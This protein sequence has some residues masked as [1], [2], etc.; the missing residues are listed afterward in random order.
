MTRLSSNPYAPERL[1]LPP[2]MT[3]QEAQNTF[4]SSS[5]ADDSIDLKELVGTLLGGWPIIVGVTIAALLLSFTYLFTTAPIYTTDALV[6]VEANQNSARIAFAQVADAVGSELPVTAEVEILRSRLVLGKIVDQLGLDVI[7]APRRFPLLGDAYARRHRGTEFGRAPWWLAPFSRSG[8]AWGGE[9]IAVS[10]LIAPPSMLGQPLVVRLDALDGTFSLLDQDRHVMASGKAGELLSVPISDDEQ[11]QLFVRELTGNPGTEFIV[12]R[13]R[14][15]AAIR[16][17]QKN[18]TVTASRT[19]LG[20]VN[21]SYSDTSPQGARRVLDAILNAYQAQNVERRSA[22]AEQTLDFLNQQL[23]ELRKQVETAEARLNQFK[24]QQGTADLGQETALVL[25]RS[26]ELEQSRS[27]LLQQRNEALQRYTSIH[28]VVQA[29][30]SQLALLDGQLRQVNARVRQLPDVEQKALQLSRDLQVNTALYVSLLNRTQ[31]LEVVKSGTIGSIRVIDT[32]IVPASPSKPRRA[33]VL[34]LS[35]V[36]G[37]LIGVV[38]VFLINALSSGVEDPSEVEKKLGLATYG[39]IPYSV[40]QSKLAQ[41][42]D[43]GKALKDGVLAV[44]EPHGTAMEAI[45]SVRTALHFAAMDAPNNVIMLTGPEPSLGKSFVSINLGGALAQAGSRVIVIDADLRRG[46]IHKMVDTDR[47]P[48]LSEL[49]SGTATFEACHRDTGISGLHLIPTGTLPPNPS[50]LLINE[51]FVE[52]LNGLSARYDHVIIDTPPVL[53]VTDAAIIGRHAGITLLVLK[54]GQHPLRMIE[55]TAN[56]LMRSGV[57]VRGTLFNQ[58]GLSR[59]S[60]YGYKYG[61]YYGGYNY[62]YATRKD[63]A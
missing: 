46:H 18:L 61:Y 35:L 27:Q 11:L 58:I 62:K 36:L 3:A 41:L 52:L 56:R 17:V 60:R 32:P 50:E 28:P 9:Q 63:T 40:E 42:L 12:R 19:A 31:E 21:L 48:G 24:I 53:A 8:T 49:I 51:R 38:S 23:P 1:R 54:A 20:M 22:E 15:D 37:G 55:E 14:R 2:F 29:I 39:A 5:D 47:G 16:E 57:Q 26:V 45:R 30:D 10:S 6:Q 25:N 59:K 44:R 7:V 43:R 34:A 4:G 33:L 13:I